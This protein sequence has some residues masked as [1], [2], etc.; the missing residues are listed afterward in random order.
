MS[1][2][3]LIAIIT[4]VVVAA[5]VGG[6]YA[7]VVKNDSRSATIGADSSAVQL[8]INGVSQN[9]T[10]TELQAGQSKTQTIQLATNNNVGLIQNG[11]EGLFSVSI[12]ATATEDEAQAAKNAA[13]LSKVTLSATDSNSVNYNA[14]TLAT[15]VKISLLTIPQDITLSVALASEEAGNY[16]FLSVAEGSV[17]LTISWTAVD[18]AIDADAYYLVGIVNG[19]DKTWDPSI[20]SYKLGAGNDENH[21]IGVF[22]FEENDLFCGVKGD[23]SD[24]ANAQNNNAI[25]NVIA[26]EE[27]NIKI[28]ASG[29]YRV[30]Y[31]KDEDTHLWVEQVQ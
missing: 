30:Y 31:N 25:E 10:L 4:V 8:T 26:I 21:A 18:F 19:S 11:A 20:N 9:F 7:A 24:W 16:D 29:T 14:A 13:L 2:K 28:L 6:A 15:G 3:L 22:H 27:G 5:I 12:A 1:K 23:K 17:T